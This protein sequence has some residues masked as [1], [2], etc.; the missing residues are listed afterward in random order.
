M[1]DAGALWATGSSLVG[2]DAI[3][4]PD[5]MVGLARR[6]LAAGQGVEGRRHDALAAAQVEA[7]AG[8]Q[9]VEHDPADHQWPVPAD[10]PCVGLGLGAVDHRDRAAA[11]DLHDVV[12]PDDAG[13]V[14]IDAEPQ[15]RR[16]LG[17]QA[18]QPAEP[19]PLLEVLVHDDARE[20]A[21][22]RRDLG[23]PVLRGRPGRTERDHVAGHRGGA[24]RGPRDDRP[25]AEPLEDRVGQARP[26]D[27]R[28]EAQ[29]VAAGE[30][31]ARRVADRERRGFVVRL[32]A[33]DRVEGPDAG[34]AQLAEDVAVALAGLEAERRG[35][36]R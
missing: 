9:G 26:A 32:R 29:L 4:R 5:G 28:R 34:D 20:H 25:V 22:A 6:G 16:V 10:L 21:E 35:G 31:D 24:R 30:E 33:G 2:A 14:L 13:G 15:Q 1:R 17:D 11:D 19:V 23:H 3:A 8:R 27:R 18:E 7:V 12:G 36:A